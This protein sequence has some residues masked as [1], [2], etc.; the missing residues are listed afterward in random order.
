MN[1]TASLAIAISAAFNVTPAQ[2]PPLPTPMP[3]A[4]TVKEYV[5]EYFADEPILVDIAQCESHM[6]QFDSNG[7]VLH[8]EVVYQDLGLMQVNET[9]HGATA[10]KLGLDLYTMQGNLAYARYLYDKEGTTPWNSSKACWSK[11]QDYKDAQAATQTVVTI[12]LNK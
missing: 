2:M 1:L 7:S 5:Q 10:A 8:G 4:Q 9:Y 6:R 11:S 3:Q 12:N